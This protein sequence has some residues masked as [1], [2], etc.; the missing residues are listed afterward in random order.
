MHFIA[1]SNRACS[2][3][4][5]VV[6]IDGKFGAAAR[7]HTCSASNLNA[8]ELMDFIAARGKFHRVGEALSL[9]ASKICQH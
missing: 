6:A 5:W 1:D 4:E 8:S 7:F 3:A 2:K 9:D